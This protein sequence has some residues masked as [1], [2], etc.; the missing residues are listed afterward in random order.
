MDRMR[1]FH[2]DERTIL[3]EN[4]FPVFGL[5]TFSQPRNFGDREETLA[6]LCN[7]ME[8]DVVGGFLGRG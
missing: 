6:R 8:W 4:K 3:K 7:E 5:E 1:R 2:I